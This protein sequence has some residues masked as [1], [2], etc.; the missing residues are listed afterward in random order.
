MSAKGVRA[1]KVAQTL[2]EAGGS[3]SSTA[4]RPGVCNRNY[5][6]PEASGPVASPWFIFVVR[7]FI[8]CIMAVLRRCLLV[9]VPLL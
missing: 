7:V 3:G 8:L 4:C 1:S 9:F 6:Y 2:L 5:A